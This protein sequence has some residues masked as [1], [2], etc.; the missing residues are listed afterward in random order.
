MLDKTDYKKQKSGSIDFF[1]G[2]ENFSQHISSEVYK[3][4]RTMTLK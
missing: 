4:E 1:K 3:H 2:W